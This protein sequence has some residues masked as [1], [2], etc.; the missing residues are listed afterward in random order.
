LPVFENNLDSVEIQDLK[1]QDE[2]DFDMGVEF[3]ENVDKK[4][5]YVHDFFSF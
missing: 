2:M 4:K 5:L 1:K 3:K